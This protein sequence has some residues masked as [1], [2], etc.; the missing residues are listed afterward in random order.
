MQLLDYPYFVHS[1]L[2]QV[3]ASIAYDVNNDQMQLEW[4][5]WT[6]ENHFVLHDKVEEQ[7]PNVE[8]EDGDENNNKKSVS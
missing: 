4:G 2:P 6:S 8:H 1:G 5:G 3:L 7:L